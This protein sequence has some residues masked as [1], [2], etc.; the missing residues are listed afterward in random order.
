MK[1]NTIIELSSYLDAKDI[2]RIESIDDLESWSKQIEGKIRSSS[3]YNFWRWRITNYNKEKTCAILGINT[4]ELE[5]TKVEVHHVIFLW[6][7]VMISGAYLLNNLPK[8]KE[9]ISMYDVVHLVLEDHLD[10]IIPYTVLTVTQ[11]QMLHDKLVELPKDKIG[12]E[13]NKYFKKYEK[14]IREIDVIK[15]HINLFFTL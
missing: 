9:Y 11:H 5:Y 4:E 12:G 10:N 15:E 14:E 1:F 3:E 2:F 13:Y 7:L 6:Y 8:D